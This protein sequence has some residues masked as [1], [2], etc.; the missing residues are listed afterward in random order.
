MI[1][2]IT[3]ATSVW[4]TCLFDALYIVVRSIQP[5]RIVPYTLGKILRAPFGKP[6]AMYAAQLLIRRRWIYRDVLVRPFATNVPSC[7]LVLC[8]DVLVHPFATNISR[9]TESFRNHGLDPERGCGESGDVNNARVVHGICRIVRFDARRVDARNTGRVDARNVDTR[10]TG[11]GCA[12]ARR[13]EA[14]PVR[15]GRDR[16]DLREEFLRRSV[17]A[18]FDGRVRSRVSRHEKWNRRGEDACEDK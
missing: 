12:D 10:N 4:T 2:K 13:I 15:W 7:H 1:A 9:A 8:R 14:R 5:G 3:S 16:L 18:R 6:I 17:P 11:S